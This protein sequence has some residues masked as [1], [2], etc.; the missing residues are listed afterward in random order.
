MLTLI[1]QFAQAHPIIAV[2]A[3]GVF[4]VSVIRAALC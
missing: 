4:W 1:Q 3:V 2:V